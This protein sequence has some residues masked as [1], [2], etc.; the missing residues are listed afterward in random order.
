MNSIFNPTSTDNGSVNEY[1]CVCMMYVCWYVCMYPA[2]HHNHHCWMSNIRLGNEGLTDH[3]VEHCVGFVGSG[4]LLYNLIPMS[5]TLLLNKSVL[6][7]W[8]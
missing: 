4:S 2:W 8:M 3:T 1:V 6:Y 5:L 7:I